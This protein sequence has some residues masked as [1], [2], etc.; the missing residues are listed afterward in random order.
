MG[1]YRSATPIAIFI[2]GCAIVSLVA[3]ALL[4]D[5]TNQDIADD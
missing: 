5:H 2:L 3:T 4:K 1:R